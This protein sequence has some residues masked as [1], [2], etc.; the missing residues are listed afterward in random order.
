M[1]KSNSRN[2]VNNVFSN[3]LNFK[4][5][6]PTC[7]VVKQELFTRQKLKFESLF[8]TDNFFY[9]FMHLNHVFFLIMGTIFND[10][11]FRLQFFMF[12]YIKTKTV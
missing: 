2:G 5:L 9:K 6:I 7:L 10:F 8:T 12:G 4:N 11:S 3:M 1:N